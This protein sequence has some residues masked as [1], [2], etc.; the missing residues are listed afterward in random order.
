MENQISEAIS[1]I[2][3]L[4]KRD[5]PISKTSASNIDQSF[6]SET[7]QKHIA[8]NKIDNFKIVKET[9]NGNP[10]ELTHDKIQI[11]SNYESNEIQEGNPATN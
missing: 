4:I 5:A 7:L 10:N 8:K 2:K 9:E 6:K 11:L 1:H 3:M